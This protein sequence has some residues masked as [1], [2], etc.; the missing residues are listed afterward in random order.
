MNSNK[1]LLGGIA[2]GIVFFL[3][4]YVFYGLLFKD[5]FAGN[6]MDANMDNFVWWAMIAGNLASGFLF[7][8]ILSK[9]NV[10]SAAGGASIAFVAGLLM[11]LGFDL[12]MYGVGQG[13][14]T[15]KGLAA[16]VAISAVMSAIT[17]AVIGWVYGMGKKAA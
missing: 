7:A 10:S 9:A 2:G 12:V 6:G 8:Y 13:L 11:S 4:G 16:D 17:G 1:F 15:L 5:F 3:L 14:S